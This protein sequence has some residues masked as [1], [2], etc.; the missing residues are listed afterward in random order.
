MTSDVLIVKTPEK[1]FH[2]SLLQDLASRIQGSFYAVSCCPYRRNELRN[3]L[4][5]KRVINPFL[6]LGSLRAKFIW[7]DEWPSLMGPSFEEFLYLM[8]SF[9][10]T[11]ILSQTTE[12][13]PES[14]KQLQFY[15]LRGKYLI[16]E[17]CSYLPL[18]PH[19]KV[20]KDFTFY[21]G[22][23]D[24]HIISK[25]YQRPE[26]GVDFIL[27]RDSHKYCFL[28]YPR[29]GVQ[30]IYHSGIDMKLWR[31]Y[32]EGL[33]RVFLLKARL[34]WKSL[35]DW[36]YADEDRRH[37]HQKGSLPG[38]PYH[39]YASFKKWAQGLGS[40]LWRTGWRKET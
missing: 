4:G 1:A 17:R 7:V 24:F 32:R 15:G 38:P 3:L 10:A 37:S 30:G 39:W 20:L 11:L 13:L 26:R 27:L 18:T 31:H 9:E 36:H 2:N 33:K 25:L 12:E 35:L 23:K 22:R 40:L 6:P 8:L 16:D 5:N 21:R 29:S 28:L 14:L 34:N 19:L